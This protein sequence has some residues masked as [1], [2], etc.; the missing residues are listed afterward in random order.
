MIS[1]PNTIAALLVVPLLALAGCATSD[2]QAAG[3]GG[4]D[5]NGSG[6]ATG[7]TSPDSEVLMPEDHE[8]GGLIGIGPNGEPPTPVDE[9]SINPSECDEIREGGYTASISMHYMQSDF[10][11]LQVAGITDTLTDCGVEVLSVTDADFDAAT[12]TDQL[13]TM[14]QE[15]P[16]V[17]FSLATDEVATAPVHK[18]VAEAGIH[19]VMIDTLPE[20]LVHG[21]DYV[22][23][24]S[25]D[26]RSMGR[27][28][29][30]ILLEQVGTN[31]QIATI[32]FGEDFFVLDEREDGARE[33]F[34]LNDVEIVT[35][36]E[37]LGPDDGQAVAEGMLTA[38]PDLRGLWVIWDTPAVGAVAAAR[39][40]GADDLW[41]STI[42]LGIE[43]GREVASGR[44][45]AGTAADTPYDGGVAEAQA[46][47][48][49]LLGKDVPPYIAH[50]PIKVT[51]EN[52]LEAWREVQKEDPP[53]ELIELCAGECGE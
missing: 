31:A 40:Q 33:V 26:N 19:L 11:R 21:D 30:Q 41:I 35:S 50:A 18:K 53:T 10:S 23:V 28:A 22:T 8:P 7:S 16:D 49:A 43:F 34:E 27:I 17:I 14:I 2:P 38:H 5:Q 45:G 47:F 44:L 1:R 24:V 39:A 29:A 37:I 6:V 52:L 12:Q 25:G 48:N 9:I 51:R 32:E 15:R 13:E 42:D 20:G 46:A 36:G 4:P 3:G